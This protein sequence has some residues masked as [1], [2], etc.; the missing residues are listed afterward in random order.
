MAGDYAKTPD[1]E[2]LH[3][4]AIRPLFHGEACIGLILAP[5]RLGRAPWLSSLFF[6]QVPG[7][8]QVAFERV[9][10]VVGLG[11]FVAVVVLVN[12]HDSDIARIDHA[13]MDAAVILQLAEG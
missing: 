4:S 3:A 8:C 2:F 11:R 12:L 13:T 9:E 7:E 10:V 6:V 5:A 1:R